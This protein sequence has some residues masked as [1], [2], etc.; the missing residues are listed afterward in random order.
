MESPTFDLD[1]HKTSETYADL[2]EEE[3]KLF[4]FIWLLL[5]EILVLI[6][7]DGERERIKEII[8]SELN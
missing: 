6:Y 7:K 1:I 4:A 8:K 5:N 2:T 3:K